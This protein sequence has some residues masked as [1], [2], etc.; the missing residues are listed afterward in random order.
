M[1]RVNLCI[2]FTAG[3]SRHCASVAND[4]G[5]V[6]RH[7]RGAAAA[8]APRGRRGPQN[9]G[10]RSRQAR[11]PGACPPRKIT[12]TQTQL[13]VFATSPMTPRFLQSSRPRWGTEQTPKV[14]GDC[15]SRVCSSSRS[16]RC[17]GC[18]A[19]RKRGARW[20]AATSWRPYVPLTTPHLTTDV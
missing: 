9:P 6:A 4:A 14:S 8:A 10:R 11:R 19:C 1:C 5:A 7:R 20:A 13:L 12:T 16:I 15:Q 2:S 18:R 17:I 3:Q